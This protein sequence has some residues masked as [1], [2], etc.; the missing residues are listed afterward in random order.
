LIRVRS[1]FP[2]RSV[3]VSLALAASVGVVAGRSMTGP[4]APTPPAVVPATR[5]ASDAA[6]HG[7]DAAGRGADAAGLTDE[8][9]RLYAA[10]HFARACDRFRTVAERDPASASRRA[11]AGRCFQGWGWQALSEGRAA[12]AMALFRQGLRDAPDSPV[13]LRG[14]GV[15]AVHAG[16]AGEAIEPLEA[17]VRL[18]DDAQVRMLLAHLYDRRDEAT[19]ASAH[20]AAVLAR[21]PAHEAARRLADRLERERRAE[22]GFERES[23]AGFAIKW[24]TDAGDDRKRLVRRLLDGARVRLQRELAFH[25]A[26]PVAVVLYPDAEF[27]AVTGAHAWASGVFDGKIRLPLGAA[28]RD[29]E[30]LVLHEYAHAAVHELGRGRAPRWLHE[31][32]AQ[33]VEGIEADPMLR[34]PPSVTLAGVEALITDPDPL[35]ARTG[36]DLA[37]WVVRDLLDRGGTPRLGDLLARL[38]RHEPLDVAFARV[39]GLTLTELESQWRRLLGS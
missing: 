2:R 27:R 15:A 30:R 35:R 26:D 9:I 32:F 18:A 25:P 29:L 37:L 16:R 6:G 36:Y 12:E 3:V 1:P 39:Y 8:A 4:A 31:G 38:G 13:L 19:R 10:G 24:P 5:V 21:E 17:A 23:A 11:D 20:L 14:F 34:V 7:A 28:E 33:A 22:A